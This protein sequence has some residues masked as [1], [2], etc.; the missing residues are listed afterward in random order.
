MLFQLSFIGDF[1]SS[2]RDF[3][4]CFGIV[5]QYR[6]G[7]SLDL[8]F[9]DGVVSIEFFGYPGLFSLETEKTFNLFSFIE[10]NRNDC[11]VD[12]KTRPRGLVF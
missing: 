5:C 2:I 11:K 4:S 7:V 12:S 6:T 3:L 1:L 9:D 10:G 8:S